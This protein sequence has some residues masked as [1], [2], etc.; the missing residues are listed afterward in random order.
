MRKLL[1]I[2]L[3]I[4]STLYLAAQDIPEHISYTR[5]YDFLDE[6][7]TD[8]VIELNSVA[9]PYSRLFIAE[10][11][12]EAE[13]NKSLNSRQRNELKFFKNEFALELKRLPDNILEIRTKTSTLA[14]LQP[15]YNYRD[16][17]FSARITPILGMHVTVNGNGAYT[18]RWFGA[19]LQTMIDKNLSVYG[20]LR[21]LSI[22]ASWLKNMPVSAALL[23]RPAYLNDYPGYEYKES[24]LGGDF[25]D[26]RGGIKYA[27]N[28]GSVGLVKDN[29]VWG[30]NYHGS[31]IL[32][33]RAPSFPM[34]TLHLKP[35]SWFEMQYIH[36]WLV[37][38]VL[39]STR[40][41]I[42]NTGA[43]EY[44]MANKFIA[45]NLFTFTPIRN[46]NLSVGNSIIYAEPNIQAAYLIPIAFYKSEDHTLTKGLG[47]ENQNSQVFMN[48][49]S[50]NIKHL[51]LFTSIYA[52]EISFSRF[53]PSSKERNPISYKVGANLS[54]FPVENL[55]I[56]AEYTNTNIVNYKHSVPALTWASNGYN[57]GSYLGDN[58]TELYLAARYKPLQGVDLSLSYTDSNHG[59]EYIYLRRDAQGADA[60]SKIISQPSLGDITWSN[61][62]LALD[63][64][65]E[66]IN[67]VYAFANLTYS[68]IKAYNLTSATI[69]GEVRLN[70]QGYLDLF[71]PKYLQGKNTTLSFGMSFG[72]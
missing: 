20:S 14:L 42:D 25:S 46:L 71:T 31:N 48:I 66:I 60:I 15:A 18:K 50:R 17:A 16:T 36:G 32:S 58:S 26:S 47:L 13:N 67:N 29:V 64:H 7:A 57:L 5:I 49:S 4:F 27:W 55:S 69:S 51:H 10:K 19:D 45:A 34:L 28:W 70:A 11:L 52:D 44:R 1:L 30:D 63:L 37:S 54:N 9:K 68:D 23:A 59:N 65:V 33:G 8:G 43:K 38:N 3:T 39:D 62:S 53:L 22:D 35:V 72:F 6:L 2:T 24:A 21:D 41:Y 56:I 12:L 61:S 40:Y